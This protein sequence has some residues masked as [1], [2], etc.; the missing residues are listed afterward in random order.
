MLDVALREDVQLEA[1]WFSKEMG[2]MVATLD[3]FVE[4]LHN[5]V[6]YF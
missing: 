6:S 2:S 3:S 1:H 4:K 5:Q